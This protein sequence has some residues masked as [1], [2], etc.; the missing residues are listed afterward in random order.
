MYHLYHRYAIYTMPPKA[1]ARAIQ[2]QL[3]DLKQ[4]A[5]Q[6]QKPATPLLAAPAVPEPQPQPQWQQTGLATDAHVCMSVARV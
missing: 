5:A 4:L 2:Y 6:P 3:E 1:T